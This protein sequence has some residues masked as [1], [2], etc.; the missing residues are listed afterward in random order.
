MLLLV[1]LLYFT[2]VHGKCY[3]H[4]NYKHIAQCDYCG[5]QKY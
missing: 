1:Q 5:G 2:A 3:H 4:E